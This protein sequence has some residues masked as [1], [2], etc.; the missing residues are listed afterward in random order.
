MLSFKF[1]WFSRDLRDIHAK[2][3]DDRPGPDAGQQKPDHHR[4]D[5]KIGFHE[6]HDGRE[7]AGCRS[8]GKLV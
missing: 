6:K 2:A 1:V 5:D 4:F 3:D 8:E 7:A